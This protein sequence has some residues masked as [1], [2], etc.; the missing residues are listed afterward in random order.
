VGLLAA[1][2]LIAAAATGGWAYF[3][4]RLGFGPLSAADKDAA[5]TIAA[6]VDGP[7]WAD[8]DQVRCAADDL[9]AERR[10]GALADSGLIE[11]DSAADHGWA[12]TGDWSD[13]DAHDFLTALLDCSETDGGW[14]AQLGAEW[15]LDDTACLS[16]LGA[17]RVAD[18]LAVDALEQDSTAATAASEKAVG[19]LDECYAAT[20]EAPEA[21]AKPGYRSVRFTFD[22][23][24]PDGA[25][26]SVAHGGE[27]TT[28]DGTTFRAE[29]A[30]GGERVCITATVSATYPW[31]TSREAE[32]ESCG[33]A[34]PK[35]L[36]WKP[37]ARCAADPKPCRSWKLTF[38]GF[39]TMEQ[40]TATL[41]QNGGDCQSVSGQCRFSVQVGSTGRGSIV[42]WSALPNWSDRFTAQVGGLTAVLPN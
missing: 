15:D 26:L 21:A 40:I 28:V 5:A 23:A 10:S 42:T 37:L 29:A 16:D 9:V 7:E 24:A 14:A 32:K 41:R 27:S 30:E 19:A 13:D 1:L 35:Q 34:E 6:E 17:G 31:G 8:E 3:T 25:E 33:R 39:R 22:E 36:T 20:L 12:F 18:F 4:G 38:A 2:V 11:K